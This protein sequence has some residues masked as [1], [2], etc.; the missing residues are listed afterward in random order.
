MASHTHPDAP[1]R[2]YPLS[3]ARRP[4]LVAELRRCVAAAQAAAPHLGV[5]PAT[6]AHHFGGWLRAH[7][8]DSYLDGY[9]AAAAVYRK[10]T[11]TSPAAL[12]RI[13][14][15]GYGS[16]ADP[17]EDGP[18]DSR[19]LAAVE[20][21]CPG[22]SAEQLVDDLVVFESH[23]HLGLVWRQCH[24]LARTFPERTADDLVGFGWLGLRRALRRYDPS[25]AAFST[26][27]VALIDGEIREGV[28]RENPL[29]KRLTTYV[30]KVDKA[31]DDLAAELGRPPRLAELAE[32][33]DQRIEDLVLLSRLTP[34]ASIDELT[35]GDEGHREAPRWMSDPVDVGVAAEQT[36]RA[37]A[38]TEAI[39]RLADADERHAAQLMLLEGRPSTE[40]EQLCGVPSRRL[41]AAK[42]RAAD[43][44]AADLSGWAPAA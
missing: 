41:L 42:R 6:L 40:A 30:R 36:V 3:Q 4:H 28:R 1:A 16:V 7:P 5:D 32:R 34:A 33:L 8:G 17:D 9:R 12:R 24:R 21:A 38:I 22:V 27:A 35:D 23:R 44:L 37:Q 31:V 43:H 39:A 2:R 13:L 11:A 18:A 20:Q 15:D 26:Y 29:P 25:V 10:A 14:T 19:T